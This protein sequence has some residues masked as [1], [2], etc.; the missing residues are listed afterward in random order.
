MPISET[1][2]LVFLQRAKSH[3]E[4]MGD[5]QNKISTFRLIINKKKILKN[6][7]VLFSPIP[8]GLQSGTGSRP[9]GWGPL[10]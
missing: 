1:P 2:E 5:F 10:G 6:S 7:N 8:N 4:V 9:G 3:L